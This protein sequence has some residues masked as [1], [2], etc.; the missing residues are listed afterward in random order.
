MGS[1]VEGAAVGRSVW[2]REEGEGVSIGENYESQN[3]RSDFGGDRRQGNWQQFNPILGV[4]LEKECSGLIFDTMG[5][6][7]EQNPIQVGE[8]GSRGGLSFGW[9]VGCSVTLRSLPAFK[10][11]LV[12]TWDDSGIVLWSKAIMHVNIPSPFAAEAMVCVEAAR[13]AYSWVFQE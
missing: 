12:S 10:G 11:N 2:L 8:V 7:L 3:S 13:W 4:N 6:D 1:Y 5:N 9:N